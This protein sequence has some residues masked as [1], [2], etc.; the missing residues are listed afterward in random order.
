[1][2][3]INT[4]VLALIAATVNVS[5]AQAESQSIDNCISAVQ[6]QKNG[7]FIK[8]E[9]LNVAGKPFYEVEIKD[10]N[11]AEWEFMCNVADGKISEQESEVPNPDNNAFKKQLKIS[12]TEASAIALK[13]YPGKVQEIEYE[14]EVNGD[15][16]YELDIVNDKK[17]ET[18][19]EVDAKS[20]K[21][22]EVSTEEWEIGE[23][24]NSKR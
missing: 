4:R 17:I 14:I 18:K 9:K 19:V 11:G 24:S 2:K 3:K 5:L 10:E 6:K 21:I 12:E 7:E 16:S 1:M 8:L 23:E 13:A 20:G 22:I 15:A